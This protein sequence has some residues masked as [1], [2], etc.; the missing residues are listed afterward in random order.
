MKTAALTL[1]LACAAACQPHPDIRIADFEGADYGAW[2]VEGTAFGTGP[3]HGTLPNQMPVSG[4]VGEGLVNS[5]FGG[6]GSTGTL[7]SPPFTIE[8]RFINFLIGG[9]RY[10]GETCLDLLVDGRVV[11]TAT[12]PNNRPGGSERLVWRSWAVSDL[13][14][15]EAVL[16]IVDSAT[17][18]WGHINVDEITQSDERVA[19]ELRTRELTIGKGYLSFPVKRGEVMRKVT[20][21]VEGGRVREFEAELTRDTPD[22]W[23]FLDVSAYRGSRVTIS[24]IAVKGKPSALELVTQ[25]DEIKRAENLYREKL[26]PQF[27]FTSRRGWNNDP[28]GL[29][30]HDGE[31]H[32]F[33]QHNPYGWSW[34]NMH[35]GHAASSDLVH[36]RELPVAIYPREFGDWVFS[37][38]AASLGDTIVAAYTSTGRGECIAFSTDRGRTFA[39][40]EGDPV[41][42]HQGRDPKLIR[43]EPGQHWVMAVYDEI[44]ESR[45]IAFYTSTDLKT[46]ERQS[47][48]EGYFECPEIFEIALDG[49]PARRRWVVYS[50]DGAYSIGAFDGRAFTPES[51]KHRY[52][53]G[54][55]F[56]ASQTFNNIPPADGRRIQIA[57]G[58]REFPGMPWNQMM[59]FPVELTLRTTDEGP[60][61]FAW[62][63]REI[64]SLRASTEEWTDL[65]VAGDA[66]PIPGAGGELLDLEAE[67]DVGT[68][69]EVGLRVRGVPITL[70]APDGKLSCSGCEAPLEAETGRIRL[71]VLVDRG[72]VEIY[73]NGGRVYMPIGVLLRDEDRAVEAFAAGGEARIVSLRVSRLRSIRSPQPDNGLKPIVYGEP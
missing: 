6:D 63:V 40:Y 28:N 46:W 11:R 48:I 64:E 47:R 73:A 31:Y 57:W 42:V 9:G 53:W 61:L 55:C 65:P 4:F 16:R 60:R 51:G 50:A 56:Y 1:V 37:G 13:L 18:G 54:N 35:W 25:D 2:T 15:R 5:Y 27:H 43:Y 36:W 3:A 32:L 19:E 33:Y 30:F 69:T 12:G 70:S 41:V 59:D 62:P 49:D 66:V 22:F 71:R 24:T 17:G 72:S 8:R 7:T 44:G 58:T 45:G 68:A 38:S 21:R 14:G 29:V 34:G 39:D 20:V 23:A 26:R 10:P 67:I 52:N